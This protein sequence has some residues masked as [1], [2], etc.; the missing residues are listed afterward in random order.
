M[1]P[2][3]IFGLFDILASLYCVDNNDG[4]IFDELSG[5]FVSLLVLLYVSVLV[6]S[7]I[8]LESSANRRCRW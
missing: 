1:C 5:R 3:F 2:K 6:E 8:V 4:D 7:T